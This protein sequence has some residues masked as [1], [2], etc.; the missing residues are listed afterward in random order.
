M[1]ML[2]IEK[3]AAKKFIELKG[4]DFLDSGKYTMSKNISNV[5]NEVKFEFLIAKANP[6]KAGAISVDERVPWD[7]IVSIYV[8]SQTGE[9]RVV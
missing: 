3:I 5:E 2:D 6:K 1:E 7:E 4:M 9:C 8:N